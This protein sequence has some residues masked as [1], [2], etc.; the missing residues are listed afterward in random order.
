MQSTPEWPGWHLHTPGAT[1]VPWPAHSTGSLSASTIARCIATDGDSSVSSYGEDSPSWT[2]EMSADALM[3]GSHAAVSSIEALST[4][5]SGR[6]GWWSGFAVGASA[7][8]YACLP[9][10]AS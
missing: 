8:P 4:D 3:R 9:V 10:A 7:K 5:G 2:S 6:I 1:H